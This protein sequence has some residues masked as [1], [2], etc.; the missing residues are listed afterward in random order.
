MA[1]TST[2]EPH[3]YQR[4]V[5][6]AH[7]P[8]ARLLAGLAIGV[9]VVGVERASAGNDAATATPQGVGR[10]GESGAPTASVRQLQNQATWDRLVAAEELVHALDPELARLARALANLELPD[11]STR[12]LFASSVSVTDVAADGLEVPRERLRAAPQVSTRTARIGTRAT[13]TA[14]ELKLWSPLLDEV[15]YLERAKFGVLGG[16]F[17]D[18]RKLRFAHDLLLQA[19]VHLRTGATASV[20]ARLR[21][22]WTR[23]DGSDPADPAAWRIAELDT[24]KLEVMESTGPLFEEVLDRAVPDAAARRSARQPEHERLVSRFLAKRQT[25]ALPYPHFTVQAH[26]RHPAVSI[27]DVDRDGW[28]DLYVM[29][30]LGRNMLFVNQRDGTFREEA[31][32]YGLDI[33]NHCS[34]AIFAD[35]DNDGDL[36]AYIGRTLAPSMFLESRNG[37][38]VDRSA[39]L[40]EEALPQLVASL[41]AADYDRDG[42]LDLYVS[43]YAA[44]IIQHGAY[45]S[46]NPAEAPVDLLAEYLTP[47]DNTALTAMIRAGKNE[48]SDLPGPPNVLLHNAGGGRFEV[49][50][51]GSALRVFRNTY[52]ASWADFDDDGDDDLYVADDFAPNSFFRNDGDGRFTDITAETGTADVGFGMGVSWGDYDE[53]GRQDLYVSNMYSKAGSRITAA[54]PVDS[55]WAKMARGNTLFRNRGTSFEQVSGQTGKM[56]RVEIAGWSWGGQFADFNNDGRLDLFVPNGYYTAPEEHALPVDI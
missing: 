19:K 40:P 3:P 18:D 37:R 7:R 11:R 10:A 52:Q 56:A 55:V 5:A 38:F 28:D 32:R 14:Q 34:S 30:E 33:E 50:A 39:D 13:A 51:E 25:F 22:V 17:L 29:P 2:I 42:L 26:D 4:A 8:L 20:S 45:D 24:Q 6:I 15:D 27:V 48:F 36:D 9:F 43:T 49:P 53:D 1:P 16:A 46:T 35:F 21:L 12:R 23:S 41:S 54:L 44:N 47:A 31:A